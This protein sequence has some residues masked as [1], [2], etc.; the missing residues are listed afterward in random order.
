MLHETC[1][2]VKNSPKSDSARA[3][4]PVTRLSPMVATMLMSC[5]RSL[6]TDLGDDPTELLLDARHGNDLPVGTT[7][8]SLEPPPTP[9]SVNSLSDCR[10]IGTIISVKKWGSATVGSKLGATLTL[11]QR[12]VYICLFFAAMCKWGWHWDDASHTEKS[13]HIYAPVP[14]T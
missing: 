2:L 4:K 1:W 10:H 3:P 11:W 9:S 12:R 7:S 6:C 14:K 5:G 13:Q 8:C